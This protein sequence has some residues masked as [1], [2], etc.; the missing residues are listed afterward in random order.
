[1]LKQT[2]RPA[3]IPEFISDIN[4]ALAYRSDTEA[5]TK[6]L[7]LIELRCDLRFLA[8]PDQ[9]AFTSAQQKNVPAE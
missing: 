8:G 4:P 6:S 1:M 3:T 9:N 2:S 5:W 7:N